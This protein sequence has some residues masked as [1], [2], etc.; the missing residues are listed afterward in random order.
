MIHK[1][2]NKFG[3]TLERI[4]LWEAKWNEEA[5]RKRCASIGKRTF[6]KGYRQKPITEDERTFPSFSDCIKYGITPEQAS[7]VNDRIFTVTA[8]DLSGHK[9]SGNVIATVGVRGSDFKRVMLD[10]RSDKWTAPMVAKELT[11]VDKLFHPHIILVENNGYQESLI[12]WIR[13]LPG[14]YDF[15]MKVQPYQTG[16]QKWSDDIG[17]PSL[18]SEFSVGAWIVALGSPTDHLAECKCTWCT[19]VN[20]MR[21]YPQVEDADTIMAMWFCREAIRL[22]MGGPVQEDTIDI[23]KNIDELSDVFDIMNIDGI[24]DND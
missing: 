19:W 9:R 13:E 1:L 5:L 21:D 14:Q 20:D 7:P 8:L 16:K 2:A 24:I 15:W 6:D 10:I 22:Y 3:L 23:P 17:L 12:Q 18:E 11:K 4:S